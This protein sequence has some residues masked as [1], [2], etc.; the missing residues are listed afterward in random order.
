EKSH[1]EVYHYEKKS[2][3]LLG[4]DWDALAADD[5]WT[6][7]EIYDRDETLLEE[8]EFVDV[9]A[10]SYVP[11]YAN[12]SAYSVAFERVPDKIIDLIPQTT[13]VKW[14]DTSLSDV[15]PDNRVYRYIGPDGA[16]AELSTINYAQASTG[17]N[18]TWEVDNYIG[19]FKQDPAQHR[20]YSDFE[21][22]TV[23]TFE[24][25]WGGG[26]LR[27]KTYYTRITTVTGIKDYFTHT[28]KADYPVDIEFIQGPQS[29]EI[30]ITSGGDIRLQGELSVP[31]DISD[32]NHKI[33]GKINLTAGGDI[34][35]TETAAIFGANPAMVAGG[36][37]YFN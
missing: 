21:N 16:E 22:V 28:L 34:V 17:D 12:G 24:D 32:P 35:Q 18:K 10:S 2:F 23:D 29:P 7:R 33:E 8:S 20:Y 3:N 26:W 31:H 5:S 9:G 19:L 11:N 13:Q 37:V 25:E 27:E 15:T 1:V 6:D 30:N 14:T 36:S 4:F